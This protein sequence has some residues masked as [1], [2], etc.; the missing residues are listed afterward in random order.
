MMSSSDNRFI[1]TVFKALAHPTRIRIL[2]LLENNPLCVCDIID[3]LKI[4]QSNTSQQLNVLKNAGLLD[5]RKEG[6]SVIYSVNNHAVYEV[7]GIIE[8]MILE[9][10][11]ETESMFRNVVKL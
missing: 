10:A 6:M 3:S 5:N 7:I 8:R 9:K 4:E 11:E 1:T 2:K